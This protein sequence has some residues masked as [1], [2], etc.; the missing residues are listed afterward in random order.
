M[1]DLEADLSD[2]PRLLDKQAFANLF[3]CSV[4]TVDRWISKGLV[5][6]IRGPGGKQLIPRS[7]AARL[8]R[9]G[10]AA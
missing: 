6:T 3:H 4:R 5:N 1:Q 2:L 7:E 8:C 9:N 10:E